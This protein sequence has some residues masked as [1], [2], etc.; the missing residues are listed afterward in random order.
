MAADRP[1]YVLAY[2]THHSHRHFYPSRFSITHIQTP[3]RVV[4]F[5]SWFSLVILEI[6][7][8]LFKAAIESTSKGNSKMILSNRVI[9]HD[10]QHTRERLFSTH[11][12]PSHCGSPLVK[13]FANKMGGRP[14][15]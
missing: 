10:A 6:S 14:I 4:S 11:A 12:C 8:L 3:T 1:I 7:Q 9:I 13:C 15:G 5:T 2:V